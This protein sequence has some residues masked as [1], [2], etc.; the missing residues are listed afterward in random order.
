MRFQVDLQAQ[1]LCWSGGM[2]SWLMLKTATEDML[3]FSRIVLLGGMGE[4]LPSLILIYQEA[5]TFVGNT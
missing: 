2:M 3:V 4:F 5:L 1:K